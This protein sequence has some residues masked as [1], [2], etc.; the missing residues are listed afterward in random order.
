MYINVHDCVHVHV[1]CYYWCWYSVFAWLF[2]YPGRLLEHQF[3]SITLE[4]VVKLLRWPVRAPAAKAGGLE[5]G[6]QWLPW[7]IFVFS[8]LT[9][10]GGTKDLWCS[11]TVRLLSTQT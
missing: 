10:V 8:W 3:R 1:S 6:P 5:F 7:V 4:A 9:N 11:S 2:I